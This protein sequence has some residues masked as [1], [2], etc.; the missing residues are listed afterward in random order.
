MSELEKEFAK[1]ITNFLDQKEISPDIEQKLFQA[2]Q[3]ALFEQSKAELN[4]PVIALFFNFQFFLMMILLL[5]VL[6]SINNQQS[7]VST[8]FLEQER[9]EAKLITE[10]ETLFKQ[11]N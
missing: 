1:K 2:R 5:I 9:I 4:K 6:F 11:D 7:N 10:I 8:I 3:K